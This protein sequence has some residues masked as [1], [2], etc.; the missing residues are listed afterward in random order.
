[1]IIGSPDTV[2]NQGPNLMAA[3]GPSFLHAGR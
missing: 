3:R 1:M 2:S